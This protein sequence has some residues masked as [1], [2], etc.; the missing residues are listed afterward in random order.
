[1]APASAAGGLSLSPSQVDIP[2]RA[3]S[4]IKPVALHN[5][6][7]RP[8]DVR[9]GVAS[10]SQAPTGL[11][12]LDTSPSGRARAARLI[13]VR[14]RRLTLRPGATARIGARVLRRPG[15]AMGAY[16]AITF[17]ARPV[18]ASSKDISPALLLGA[19]LLLRFPGRFWPRMNVEALHPQQ[20][21]PRKLGVR[22][23]V[24]NHGNVHAQ[25]R[26]KV[27]LSDERGAVLEEDR[28][29]PANVLP[30][31]TRI[32]QVPIRRSLPAGRYWL[33]AGGQR[34][35]FTLVA[36]DTLPT[37][38]LAFDRVIAPQTDAGER[39]ELPVAVRSEGNTPAHGRVVARMAD[40]AG[41]VVGT[42]TVAIPDLQPGAGATRRIGLPGVPEGAYRVSLHLEVDGGTSSDDSVEFA[43]HAQPGLVDRI[44]DWMAGQNLGLLAVIGALVLL[45]G[46]M[47][48][49]MRRLRRLTKAARYG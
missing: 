15:A 8:V 22:V 25:A 33:R 46:A 45:V 44:R 4:P 43:T 34:T 21:A 16:A 41:Q 48:Q 9:V 3:G 38:R 30:G 37:P 18:H 24:S 17:T 39:F 36:R 7:R 32:F 40:R 26:R 19:N 12:V 14:H 31:A 42:A 1:M 2:V 11:A 47:A 35:S 5:G 27:V 13:A 23:D 20:T 10:L 6:S 49:H 29:N 28:L